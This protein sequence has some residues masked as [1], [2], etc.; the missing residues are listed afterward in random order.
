[1][2]KIWSCQ[3][4]AVILQP[5]LNPKILMSMMKKKILFASMIVFAGILVSCNQKDPVQ[6]Q[7]NT[8]SS[9]VNI[10]TTESSPYLDLYES[11]DELIGHV[12][13][14]ECRVRP[15]Q[16]SSIREQNVGPKTIYIDED[17]KIGLTITDSYKVDT[18]NKLE[19]KF[20][21]ERSVSVISNDANNVSSSSKKPSRQF[22]GSTDFVINVRE[23][24]PISITSPYSED[25]QDYPSCYYEDMVVKWN[26]D[27]YNDNG[28]V[29][30]VEWNGMVLSGPDYSS[31]VVGIDIVEDTG[32][33][34]LNNHLF[35]NI[36]DGAFV[37]L[38]LLRGNI[39]ELLEDNEELTMEDLQHLLANNPDVIEEYLNNNP[40]VMMQLQQV[41]CVCGSYANLAIFLVRDL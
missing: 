39:V 23:T 26:A 2:V 6:G 14:T 18:T 40:D 22:T 38:W 28:V 15:H 27:P 17:K 30:I 16:Y 8:T 10:V 5:N 7:Q 31:T 13:F 12:V 21:I 29:V 11:E 32:E 36:P 4:K 34:T 3:K 24:E 35:D 19:T 20:Y 33:A 37:N 41:V 1:M 9:K 25:G